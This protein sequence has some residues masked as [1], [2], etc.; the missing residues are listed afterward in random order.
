MAFASEEKN[1]CLLDIVGEIV[2]IRGDEIGSTLAPWD[3]VGPYGGA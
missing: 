1:V 2:S 3:G